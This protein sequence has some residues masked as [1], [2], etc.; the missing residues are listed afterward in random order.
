M[1]IEVYK[2]G[3]CTRNDISFVNADY[4][5][6]FFIVCQSNGVLFDIMAETTDKESYCVEES[7]G[8]Y[9]AK[10]IIDTIIGQIKNSI[11]VTSKIIPYTL[12]TNYEEHSFLTY[13]DEELFEKNEQLDK[14]MENVLGEIKD[15][16]AEYDVR[17]LLSVGFKILT[18]EERDILK[19]AVDEYKHKMENLY[20][21]LAQYI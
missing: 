16:G 14:I 13:Y 20:P 9:E 19:N 18:K 12:K 7:V 15:D 2:N 10:Y 8:Y 3:N 17:V 1:F 5:K 21:I 4:V 11:N 6:R